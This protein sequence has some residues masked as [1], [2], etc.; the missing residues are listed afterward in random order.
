VAETNTG[1]DAPKPPEVPA[2]RAGIDADRRRRPR[3]I[4]NEREALRQLTTTVTA[5]AVVL[6]GAL[7]VQ[8]ATTQMS[9]GD[10][11][12]AILAVISTL[13]PGSVRPPNE[14]P[15]PT[16]TPPVAVTGAS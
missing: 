15:L 4:N 16:P 5:A 13:F 10:L 6:T 11:D 14:A 9:P 8:T 2:W 3:R 1:G 12:N 7:F